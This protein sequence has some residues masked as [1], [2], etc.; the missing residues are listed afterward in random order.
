MGSMS[1]TEAPEAPRPLVVLGAGYAGLTIAEEVRRRSKGSIPVV[2]VDRH[3]VHVLRV[4]L[5]E[6]GEIAGAGTDVA[7]W[8]IPLGRVFERTGVT[9]QQ[10]EVRAIDLERRVVRVDDRELAFGALAICLG[11]V[12]SYYGVPGAPENTF[13]VY[14][15]SGAQRLA[16][17]LLD[18]E[19]SS[20]SLPGERRPRVVVVGGGSTGTELAAEVATT[21]WAKLVGGPARAPD[22]FLLTGS[23]P[24][25]AGF[26]PRLIDHARRTLREVG[27]TVV[28][29]WNVVRVEPNRVHLEDGTVLASDAA[30]WCA[31]VEAPGVVR[32]LPI[33]HGRGGRVAVEPT[34]QVPGHPDVYAVGDVAEHK[35]PETG[36][37]APATAQ[38]ALAEA[39]VVA[40]SIV[41]RAAGG[42]AEPF[43]YRER[44]VIVALGV[45]RA[46]GRLSRVTVWGSPARL[47]KRLVE[48]EY[49]RSTERGEPS[50]FL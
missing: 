28:P 21:D 42:P 13:N 47:L 41:A 20:G 43:R 29:G 49:S 17:A 33:P 15:L 24:F 44:G 6:I 18:R 27:V 39:R 35:D 46:A 12:A 37:V 25:L 11:N 16:R 50:R 40:R 38:A 2:L 26:P 4:E 1:S 7:R 19:R 34:L 31:G 14:R 45:G 3:P 8:V 48:R 10:G 5:Y 36:L 22:V 23:L 30:V 9:V 32:E